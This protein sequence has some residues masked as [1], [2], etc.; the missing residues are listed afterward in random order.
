[1][2]FPYFY[3]LIELL[4]F[5]CAVSQFLDA[6]RA[7]KPGLGSERSVSASTLLPAS[8]NVGLVPLVHGVSLFL[9]SSIFFCSRQAARFFKRPC[10]NVQVCNSHCVLGRRLVARGVLPLAPLQGS[11]L[12]FSLTSLFVGL[13]G[14]SGR[15]QF[16]S[17]RSRMT[18]YHQTSP[19]NQESIVATGGA[20]LSGIAVASPGAPNRKCKPRLTYGD[21][22][23]KRTHCLL[24]MPRATS[25]GRICA[26]ASQVFSSLPKKLSL[27]V[28]RDDRQATYHMRDEQRRFSKEETCCEL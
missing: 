19:H 16:A 8:Q 28:K 13:M 25:C 4:V 15:R 14:V 18:S 27:L 11:L 17:T 1:M 9:L 22:R 12:P 10:H 21:P 7:G 6:R 24:C 26:C 5:L 3:R 2:Y 20:S 23:I